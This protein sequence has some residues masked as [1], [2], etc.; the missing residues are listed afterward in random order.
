MAAYGEELEIAGFTGRCELNGARVL[1]A[2]HTNGSRWRCIVVDT[3][4]TIDVNPERLVACGTQDAWVYANRLKFLQAVPRTPQAAEAAAAAVEAAAA[5]AKR[6]RT[7]K[8]RRVEAAAVAASATERTTELTTDGLATTFGHL[9]LAN[10]LAAA[11]VCKAWHAG[12]CITIRDEDWQVRMLRTDQM[13]K[14]TSMM[15]LPPETTR[16]WL[17]AHSQASASLDVRT[18]VSFGASRA[19]LLQRLDHAWRVELTEQKSCLQINLDTLRHNMSGDTVAEADA[20]LRESNALEEGRAVASLVREDEGGESFIKVM[21][22]G[23]Q[24]AAFPRSKH[25]SV[26]AGLCRLLRHPSYASWPPS[27]QRQHPWA[28]R[29][30]K[31]EVLG[32]SSEG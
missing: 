18:L 5:A 2:G 27:M 20:C 17:Q 31:A 28:I 11:R 7:A 19:V 3:G 4:E 15:C 8:K 14:F 6:E 24:V 10:V 25:P 13:L 32:S 30:I 26:A 29:T 16:R 9:D 1:V 12:T 21:I 22:C 23:T